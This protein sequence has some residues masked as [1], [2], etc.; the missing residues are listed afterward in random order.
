MHHAQN[1]DAMITM[2]ADG[3]LPADRIL[4]FYQPW[5]KVHV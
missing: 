2:D 3:Q 1:Y 5:K 4:I